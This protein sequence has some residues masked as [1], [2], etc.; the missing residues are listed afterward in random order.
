[1]LELLIL[2]IILV[3]LSF[4]FVVVRGAP[5]LPTL[6]QPLQEAY[7]M[8]DLRPGDRLLELGSGDGRMLRLAA[9]Q[10]VYAIGYELNPILV[11]WTRLRHWRYRKYIQVYWR[12]FWLTEWPPSDAVYVFLIDRYMNR[13]HNRLIRYCGKN[14]LKVVSNSFAIPD[15]QPTLKKNT[16]YLYTYP[17]P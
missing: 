16:H 10:G 13:L 7:S 15:M 1:M 11:I 12:D 9:E 6:N 4:G 3:V 8:M 2:I 17:M 14:K 5:Y